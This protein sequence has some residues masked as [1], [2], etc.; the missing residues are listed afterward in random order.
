[1]GF[2]SVGLGMVSDET[3]EKIKANKERLERLSERDDTAGQL[4][5]GYLELAESA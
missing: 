5:K 2:A 3:I 1:M 4:A